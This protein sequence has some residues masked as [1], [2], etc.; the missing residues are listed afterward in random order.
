M[1]CFL[2]IVPLLLFLSCVND[3]AS[4]ISYSKETLKDDRI[5]IICQYLDT[6]TSQSDSIGYATMLKTGELAIISGRKGEPGGYQFAPPPKS[7]EALFANGISWILRI[8][9]KQCVLIRFREHNSPGI[10][11]YLIYHSVVADSC[12]Y[13]KGKS[14]LDSINLNNI[15]YY[16]IDS[17]WSI[18]AE[19]TY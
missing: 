4:F 12:T 6:V 16:H 18:S 15:G 10:D 17:H 13:F 1:R 14:Q 9:S 19:K 8:R 3:N 2:F 7:T 5:T 11:R